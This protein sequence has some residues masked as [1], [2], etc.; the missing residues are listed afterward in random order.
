MSVNELIHSRRSF[1]TLIPRWPTASCVAYTVVQF[2]VH[3]CTGGLSSHYL[4]VGG[5]IDIGSTECQRRIK[6][7]PFRGLI[8]KTS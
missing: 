3:D 5:T 4:S 7:V 2:V 6:T 1:N 8:Y